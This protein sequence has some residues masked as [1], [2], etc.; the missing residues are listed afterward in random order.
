MSAGSEGLC[1]LHY[2]FLLSSLTFAHT[3]THSLSLSFT[4]HYKR[5]RAHVYVCSELH[6]FFKTRFIHQCPLLSS[7]CPVQRS[8]WANCSRP[9]NY[10]S[11]VAENL[12]GFIFRG[13]TYFVLYDLRSRQHFVVSRLRIILLPRHHSTKRYVNQ[14]ETT[15]CNIV[16]SLVSSCTYI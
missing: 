1:R 16:S 2:Y 12:C 4:L 10:P 13:S 7:A 11:F 5:V 15:L 9:V 14:H 8:H 6:S 3:H